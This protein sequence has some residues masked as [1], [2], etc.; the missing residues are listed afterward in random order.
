MREAGA[1]KR[2]DEGAVD[3]GAEIGVLHRVAQHVV[4]D[5]QDGVADRYDCFLLAAAGDET[6]V[7][8]SEVGVAGSTAGVRG[9]DERAA[10]PGI[11]LA[12][13]ATLAFA[14]LSLWH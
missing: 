3:S 14:A 4:G 5:G 12:R 1:H 13:L 11:T 8:R 2:A 7:L 10:E 6:V 9:L